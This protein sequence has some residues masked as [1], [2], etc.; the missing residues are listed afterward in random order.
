MLTAMRD[1]PDFVLE[2]RGRDGAPRFSVSL[3]PSEGW[4]IVAAGDRIV[5]AVDAGLV[6][7]SIEGSDVVRREDRLVRDLAVASDR[8]ISAAFD[9]AGALV[10][11]DARTLA[12]ITT[13]TLGAALHAV[14]VLD[15]GRLAASDQHGQVRI[16]DEDEERVWLRRPV[17]MVSIAALPG[18][19]L[20]AAGLQKTVF[21]VGERGK[22]GCWEGLR[23]IPYRV[24][25]SGDEIA[26]SVGKTIWLARATGDTS[27]LELAAHT[28]LV[29]AL[30][31]DA[32]G[33]L[34][35]A[36]EEGWIHAWPPEARV[37]GGK[38]ARSIAGRGS[39]RALAV[40]NEGLYVLR[41]ARG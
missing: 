39:I 20:A 4:A 21:V 9:P 37:R 11:R 18:A 30:A 31:F 33:T 34:W 12:P 36:G 28:G 10:T 1:L 22:L 24:A 38:P 3:G 2:G 40:T 32:A 35:S 15:D 41:R 23:T 14:A 5:A 6:S 29:G 19:R 26:A 25:S 16:L 13:R 17:A 8:V 27:P 7:V